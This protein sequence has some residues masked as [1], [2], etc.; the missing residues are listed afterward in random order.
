MADKLLEKIPKRD[1]RF[2]D[3]LNFDNEKYYF[4][5]PTYPEKVQDLINLM[6]LHKAVDPSSIPTRIL[7]D[8]KTRLSIPLSQ[9]INLPFNKGVFPSSLMF[10]KVIP[11][12]G[13][14]LYYQT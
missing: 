8:F 11:I 6:E 13:Q 12:I 1:K 4:I 14:S 5:S 10:A 3:F 7:K 2:N 9:L